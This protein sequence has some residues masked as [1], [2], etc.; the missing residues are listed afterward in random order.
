MVETE[1]LT[2]DLKQTFENKSSIASNFLC[3]DITF[4]DFFSLKH[5]EVIM[6]KTHHNVQQIKLSVALFHSQFDTKGD[7]Q[8][9][10]GVSFSIAYLGHTTALSQCSFLGHQHCELPYVEELLYLP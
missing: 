5:S 4:Y 3:N 6:M 9:T 1:F 8:L 10:F 7:S 2:K